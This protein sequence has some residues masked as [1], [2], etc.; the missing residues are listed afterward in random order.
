MVYIY[1]MEYY[2]VSKKNDVMIFTDKWVEKEMFIL[3]EVNSEPG[4][5]T[6]N[7]FSHVWILALNL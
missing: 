6:A 4:K 2:S 5:Q 7:V 1:T 3:S